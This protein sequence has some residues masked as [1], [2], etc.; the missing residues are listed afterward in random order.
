MVDEQ[1]L[2]DLKTWYQVRGALDLCVCF[3][4]TAPMEACA[5]PPSGPYRPRVLRGSVH[6]ALASRDRVPHLAAR[7]KKW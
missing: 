3:R 7:Q 1:D 2:Q 5:K 4:N 6:G